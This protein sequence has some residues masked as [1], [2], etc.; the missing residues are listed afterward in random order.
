MKQLGDLVLGLQ[1]IGIPTDCFDKT[2]AFYQSLGFTI[3]HA[4]IH[5]SNR[6][7]FLKLSDVVMEVYEDEDAAMYRGAIDHVALNVSD[8]QGAHSLVRN[9]GYWELE[10]GIQTLP[11]FTNG[12]SYF[13][14]EGPNA[15]KIEFSQYL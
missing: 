11:F 1:H 15:E 13:T 2:I 4:T 5:D 3:I 9:L 10:G 8:I 14:I 7:A 6:V 12:V